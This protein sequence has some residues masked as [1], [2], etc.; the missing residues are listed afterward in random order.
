MSYKQ[1]EVLLSTILTNTFTH[2][3]LILQHLCERANPEH[4]QI[5]L[6]QLKLL[7]QYFNNYIFL[8]SLLYKCWLLGMIWESRLVYEVC[9]LSLTSVRILCACLIAEFGHMW[10]VDYNKHM[11]G[12]L[13]MLKYWNHMLLHGKLCLIKE[14]K[15]NL[16]M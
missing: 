16:R 9:L 15:Q 7:P 12:R 3:S 8:L 1:S 13:K 2:Y 11:G 10:L 5:N 6:L 4:F 14:T